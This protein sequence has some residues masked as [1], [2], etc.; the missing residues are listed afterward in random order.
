MS[1]REKLE[2]LERRRAEAELGGGAEQ[3]KAVLGP[4]AGGAVYSPAITDFI[5]MVRGTSYM[6]VTGPNVVKTVTHEEVTMEGLGGADVHGATSGVAHFVHDSELACLQSVRELF[7]YIPSNNLADPPRGPGT[8]PRDRRD[9]SL[10][11]IVPDNANRP[12]D[13]HEVIRRV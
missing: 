12:Y 2:L 5:Y 1:M 7:R 3:I 8:D 10:L 13:M 11:D 9:E 6:F 4:C